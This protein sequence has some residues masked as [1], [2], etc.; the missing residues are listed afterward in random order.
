MSYYDSEDEAV[1]TEWIEAK[2]PFKALARSL[3][4]VFNDARHYLARIIDPPQYTYFVGLVTRPDGYVGGARGV[5]NVP[6]NTPY[7]IIDLVAMSKP[8]VFALTS[9]YVGDENQLFGCGTVPA[10]M[11]APGVEN[12]GVR[13]K[14]VQRG[15]TVQID[16]VNVTKSEAPEHLF[17]TMKVRSRWRS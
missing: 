16:F 5:A 14:E 1:R 3:L 6:C 10:E 4:A 9:W 2:A 17:I 13:T 12:R 11:F 15:Q 8:G 7:E